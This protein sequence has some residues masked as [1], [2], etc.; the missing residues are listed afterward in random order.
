MQMASVN[1]WPEMDKYLLVILAF[2]GGCIGSA[3]GGL[4]AM[5]LI[6][7]GKLIKVELRRTLHPHMVAA[8]TVGDTTVESKT[9]GRILCFFF[10]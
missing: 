10:L 2:F 1:T 8:I 9:L 5:R 3:T 6:V 7:L 4:K